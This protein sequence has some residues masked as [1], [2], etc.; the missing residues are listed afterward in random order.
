MC[1]IYIVCLMY[2]MVVGL[3]AQ[4]LAQQKLYIYF[5][6]G[7]LSMQPRFQDQSQERDPGN[8]FNVHSF[9]ECLGFV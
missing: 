9:S 5:K 8:G 3:I 1:S 6:L 2:A 7:Q 4:I